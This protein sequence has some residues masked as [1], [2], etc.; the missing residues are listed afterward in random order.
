[1]EHRV[2]DV[3]QKSQQSVTEQDSNQDGVSIGKKKSTD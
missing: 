2:N 1:M 3:S